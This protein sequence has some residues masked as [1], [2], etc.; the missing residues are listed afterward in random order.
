MAIYL[1]WHAWWLVPTLVAWDMAV[2]AG[3]VA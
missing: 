3:S 2:K 1:Y